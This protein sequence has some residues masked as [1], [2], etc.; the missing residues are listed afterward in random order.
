MSARGRLCL[1][2]LALLAPGAIAHA[3]ADVGVV[4]LLSWDGVRHDYPERTEL[5]ALARMA[6]D[7]VRAGRLVPVYP[8]S[9]FPT[10]V[11]LATGTYPDRHGIIDN[12]FLDRS[13]PPGED[14]FDKSADADWIEAEPLWIAAE[15]QGAPAAVYFW[16]GSE[17]DWRGR[18]PGRR[19]APFDG[20]RPEAD[21]VDRILQW[22]AL[23]DGE[24]PR[25]VMSYWGG[26]DDAGHDRGPDHAAVQAAL[27][28]Q[29]A[30]L[31]RLLSGIDALGL[32]PR[33]TLIVVSDHGMTRAGP[34]LDV[35]RALARAGIDARVTGTALA[36]IYLEDPAQRDAA[37]AALTALEPL[38]VYARDDIPPSWRVTHARRTGD[39]VAA[40]PVPY[41]LSWPGGAA[42]WLR[43]AAQRLGF[44]FGVHGHH[45]EHP[46]MA[47][48]FYAYGRGV[49]RDLVLPE[50]QQVDVAASVAL[51]LGIDPPRDSEGRPIPGIGERL[52]TRHAG[53]AP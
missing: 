28:T 15:R 30:E 3:A 14:R 13:R 36:Q 18:R 5:P 11:S 42:G 40:A 2:L 16:P 6:R 37:V 45:P 44:E 20:R 7:G 38:E 52:M 48:I 8:S 47:G 29:D 25:L 39:L 49:H 1:I 41:V 24:R 26:A 4:V 17:T 10:H 33:L 43:S 19:E 46:D 31:A 23:P 27:R 32:W 22:L 34:Y 53:D 50:V 12:R 21:K 9:T 35:R 51:L